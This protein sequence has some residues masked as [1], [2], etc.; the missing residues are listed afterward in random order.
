MFCAR[1]VRGALAVGL[2]L[3]SSFVAAQQRPGAPGVR[4]RR[5]K[6]SANPHHPFLG[7]LARQEMEALAVSTSRVG[8]HLQSHT[9]RCHPM[10]RTC[11][12]L[13]P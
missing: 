4:W 12:C 7:P 2:A 8:I 6:E 13:F 1:L 5:L 3:S 9:S 10:A 11:T